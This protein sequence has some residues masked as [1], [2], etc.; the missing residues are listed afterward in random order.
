MR[1]DKYLKLTRLIKRRTI[2]KELLE[3][4]IFLVNGKVAKPSTEIKSGDII[5]LPLGKHKLT[6]EVLNC[7][8]YVKKSDAT[9]LYKILKDEIIPNDEIKSIEE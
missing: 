1:I 3:R 9:E 6:V 8:D 5:I 7:V 4:G 2:A